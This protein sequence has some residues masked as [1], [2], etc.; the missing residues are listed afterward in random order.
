MS[1][2]SILAVIGSEMSGSAKAMV[3]ILS[4]G[5]LAMIT[6]EATTS[7]LTDPQSAVKYEPAGKTVFFR[8]ATTDAYQGPNMA[9]FFAEDS[10]PRAYIFSIIA[11]LTVWE[12]RMRFRSV[13]ALKGLKCLDATG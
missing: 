6:P 3:P 5:N 7:D 1:S 8:T 4:E 2:A 12:K 10:T 9:N 13:R 11:V